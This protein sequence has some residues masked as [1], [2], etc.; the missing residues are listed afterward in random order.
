M[1]MERFWNQEKAFRKWIVR[2][3]VDGYVLNCEKGA[4]RAAHGRPYLLHRAECRTLTDQNPRT[5]R[6]FTTSK[7]Y[8]V[9]S[10]DVAELARWSKRVTGDTV[11]ECKV[12]LTEHA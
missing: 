5:G 9:C 7:Y 4:N 3:S 8:K 12:C 2:H 11:P 1:P 6:N 10:T